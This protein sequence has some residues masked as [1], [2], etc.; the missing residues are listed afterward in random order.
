M[1][2]WQVE[3]TPPTTPAIATSGHIPTVVIVPAL[4]HV[5]LSA[6]LS[7]PA[8]AAIPKPSFGQAF[9]GTQV[10]TEPLIVPS[11]HG[12]TLSIT[13]STAA[14]SRGLDFCKINLHARLVLNKG[15]KLYATK[16]HHCQVTEF[17]ESKRVMEYAFPWPRVL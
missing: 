15:D 6:S 16:R 1:F 5:A 8:Q 10:Q 9:R 11:I 17:M 7:T 3:L 12:E 13:I 2:D 4:E 14:Y